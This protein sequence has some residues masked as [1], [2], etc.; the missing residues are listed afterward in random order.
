VGG[1]LRI[2]QERSQ[3]WESAYRQLTV[4]YRIAYHLQG[5][6]PVEEKLNKV[7][8]LAIGALKAERGLLFGYEPSSDELFSRVAFSKTREDRGRL[9]WVRAVSRRVIDSDEPMASGPNLAFGAAVTRPPNGRTFIAAPLRTPRGIH[10]SLYLDSRS[11]LVSW[12]P[13]D[14]EFVRTLAAQIGMT[15]DQEHYSNEMIQKTEIERELSIARRIQQGL[16]PSS[17]HVRA[18]L[19]AHGRSVAS[20]EVGGDYYDTFLSRNG[21]TYWLMADV[22]GKGVPAAL[23][24]AQVRSQL[25]AMGR[26]GLPP[27]VILTDLNESLFED[28]D[29]SMYVTCVLGTVHPER[30]KLRY[31]N[32]GH[33]YPTLLSKHGGDLVTLEEGSYPCGLFGGVEYQAVEIDFTPGE[34]LLLATDGVVDSQNIQE[35]RFGPERFQELMAH[36]TDLT[37]M[38]LVETIFAATQEWGSGAPQRDD[39]TLLA[40]EYPLET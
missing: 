34:T 17:L 8:K 4:L 25:R 16:Q 31:V 38:E 23:V 33:E 11:D 14:V 29:G 3:K 20:K 39:I 10:G 30:K 6:D 32:A 12:G 13:G 18:P 15:F 26:N 9:D 24:Q 19:K 37:A 1:T 21:V 2:L 22:S 7:M 40:L 27:E 36:S 35:E 5:G 28:Y